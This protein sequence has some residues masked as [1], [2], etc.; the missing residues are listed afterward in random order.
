MKSKSGIFVIGCLGFIGIFVLIAIISAA[1]IWSHRNTA[2]AL[3]EQIKSQHVANKSNYDNMWKRFK[4]MAQVTDMQADDIKK[5]YTDLIAGRY[6]DTQVLFKIVQ[7]QNPQMSKDVYN[8]LQNE[9]SAGR[10]EFDRNQ[11]KIADLVREYNTHIR[12]HIVMNA[13]FHFQTMDAEKFIITSDR[14]TDA[15]QTGKD[16]EVK[17]R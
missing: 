2:I 7:E 13:I 3:D 17:L 9:I 16:N 4:E 8:K 1:M 14:T 15:Y 10:T 11:K 5:V 6:N 12:K